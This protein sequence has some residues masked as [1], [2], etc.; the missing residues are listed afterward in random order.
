M[1][2]V[3]TA[4]AYLEI[5]L[6]FAPP[7]D[8]ELHQLADAV[9]IEHL[10]GVVLQDADLIVHRQE[11]VLR[12]LTGEGEGRLGQVVGAEAEEIHLVGERAGAHAGTYHLDHGT[13]T[14]AWLDTERFSH[15]GTNGIDALAYRGQLMAGADLWHHNLRMHVNTL[16]LTRAGSLQHCAN[17]HGI[18]F[19][20]G[21]AETDAAMAEHRVDLEQCAHLLQNGLLLFDGLIDQ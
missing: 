11:F 17:L 21:D 12:I 2:A 6:Y 7:V 4:D 1:T 16:L 14:E 8:S 10:E 9:G 20:K 3:F 15:L 19:R 18:D 5:R 13:K